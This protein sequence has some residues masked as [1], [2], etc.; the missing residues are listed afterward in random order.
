MLIPA[1]IP[2]VKQQEPHPYTDSTKESGRSSFSEYLERATA[3]DSDDG[4]SDTRY[5]A[6]SAEDSSLSISRRSDEGDQASRAKVGDERALKDTVESSRG[7]G[8]QRRD[9]PVA[10]K[11]PSK[12]LDDPTRESGDREKLEER[13]SLVGAHE[14]VVQ[15]EPAQRLRK[16]ETPTTKDRRAVRDHVGRS[17]A[18]KAPPG[19]GTGHIDGD[20]GEAS[21]F[22]GKSDAATAVNEFESDSESGASRPFFDKDRTV[23]QRPTGT[24]VEGAPQPV[25]AAT[26]AVSG[27]T[28]GTIP[29]REGEPADRSERTAR[30]LQRTGAARAEASPELV[31]KVAAVEHESAH[32]T[33]TEPVVR[34]IIV[35]LSP[36]PGEEGVR[37]PFVQT[38]H[39][40]APENAVQLGSSRFIPQ[41]QLARRLN[42]DLGRSI[43][44]QANVVLRDADRGEIRLVIRPPELGRVR[45]NLQ[46]E[47]GHI[48]GR[49]LVDNGSVRDVFEQNLGAL[50]RA[51]A[52]AGIELGELEI[53]AGGE[54][55]QEPK[56]NGGAGAD[57]RTGVD[58][59]SK[60]VEPLVRL[61]HGGRH[62]DLVA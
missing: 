32:T 58:R 36:E 54:R 47:N 29:Q 55:R 15:M 33:R 5:A 53:S 22:G 21:P 35:D 60:S 16:M 40:G 20:T 3:R 44:R 56:E 28:A 62:V 39:H 10:E 38:A 13:D 4:E 26:A 8:D 14:A 45:I 34:E 51:F 52:E 42:G 23:P 6:A 46:M 59:L 31:H 12:R 17:E 43:V 18:M 41:A 25:A 9:P 19:A 48:A 37:A 49:I 57:R 1:T 11:T 27:R 30:K 2:I 24:S 50:Q 7:G 61:D